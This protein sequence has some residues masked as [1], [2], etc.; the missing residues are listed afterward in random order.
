MT[1]T[2]YSDAII[3]PRTT[4]YAERQM[5]KHAMPHIVLDKFGLQKQM[6]KNKSQTIKFRRPRTFSANTA[7][8]TEGVTPAAVPF[9]Y[10][11]VSVSLKQYGMLVSITDVIED[12]HEDPVLND[13]TLQVG[14][15]I[16]RTREALTYGVLKA[17]TSVFYANGA[18]RA[19]VN[20]KVSTSKVR[21]VIR[22]LRGNKA[23][24]I[25]Q[26]LAPSPDYQTRAVEASYIAVTHTDVEQDIR[27]LTGFTKVAEYG[28][29][30]PVSEHELGTYESVRFIT[31]A[32]LSPW[33]DA[34]GAHGGTVVT[35]SGTKADVYPILFFGR[36]AY[37]IVALRGMG[38]I[39]PAIIPVNQRDKS[40]PLGQIGYV[41]YKMWFACVILNQTWMSRL[42]VA[43]SVL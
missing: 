18:S 38:A 40:D 10:D 43:V 1:T 13:A 15:N 6:P 32:D 30:R 12:T 24:T 20:T 23:A 34:G 37:G 28:Q 41:G 26:I 27:D 31:S 3:S 36:E 29:R 25:T 9:G 42:E 35:T 14:E 8:L 17:G 2:L 22:Y 39:S 16:G 11:D 7:P 21:A 5:L 19:A 4:V 33:E